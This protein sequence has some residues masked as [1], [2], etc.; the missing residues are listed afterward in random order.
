MSGR[1]ATDDDIIRHQQ[2]RDRAEAEADAHAEVQAERARAGLAGTRGLG[3]IFEKERES[4]TE[5]ALK[6]ATESHDR[7]PANRPGSG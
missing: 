6:R 1:T 4:E 5:Q 7:K 2:E 3:A